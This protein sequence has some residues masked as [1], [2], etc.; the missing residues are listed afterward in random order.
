MC[1]YAVV[2]WGDVL[3]DLQ[4]RQDALSWHS[5]NISDYSAGE[6]REASKAKQCFLF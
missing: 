5:P 2:I 3:G 6:W 1:V 4:Y